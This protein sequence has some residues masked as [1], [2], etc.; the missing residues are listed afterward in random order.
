M[1]QH[2]TKS[3]LK[4]RV[5]VIDPCADDYWPLN[6]PSAAE[7]A[8]IV[9]LLTA[10]EA[11]KFTQWYAAQA[12]FISTQL[13]DRCGF[14][15]FCDLK[16]HLESRVVFLVSSAYSPEEEKRTFELGASCYV[17]KPVTPSW[18]QRWRSAPVVILP[19]SLSTQPI[20]RLSA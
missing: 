12:I 17:S 13:P 14:E 9:S 6:H 8:D 15:L 10:A 16:P 2:S 3:L 19:N 11:I 5:V 4:T 7:T 20:P 18:L 1:T